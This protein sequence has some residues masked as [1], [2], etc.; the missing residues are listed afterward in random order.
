MAEGSETPGGDSGTTPGAGGRRTEG[1]LLAE[2][3]AR[4]AAESGDGALTRRA[5]AAEATVK[6]LEAHVGSLQQRLLEVE[7]EK[8][9]MSEL[10]EAQQASHEPPRRSGAPPPEGIVERELRRVK[11]RE[12]AEQQLRFEAEDRYIELDRE[13]RA[14]IERL[15]RRLSSSERDARELAGRLE[16]VQREL[17]EAEQAVAAERAAL[18]RAQREL[19]AR[20]TELERRAV[21]IHRGLEAERAAREHAERLLEGMRRGYRRMEG[22]VREMKGIVAR[23]TAAP[24]GVPRDLR[25][26][27]TAQEAP[28]ER[29]TPGVPRREEEA[30]GTS[31]GSGE[32]RGGEMADALAAAVERLRARVEEVDETLAPA[33]DALIERGA[34]SPRQATAPVKRS[35]SHKHS[36]SLLT[37]LRIRRKR[38][39]QR[40]SAAA[41]PP[42]MQSE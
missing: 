7:D 24:G 21:E 23:L 22:L 25:R 11:Q 28:S 3:R 15:S 18:R 33:G 27:P 6:T 1:D 37:R 26:L 14:E 31:S 5:E 39:R 9:R 8:R 30:S 12:Y 19:Q 2:R 29:L 34:P 17:A 41:E 40:R 42:S 38:R 13:S 16:S 10:L 35:P 20:L 32:A 4:R 36:M